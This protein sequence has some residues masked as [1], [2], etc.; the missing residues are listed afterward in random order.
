MQTHDPYR[1]QESLLQ[2]YAEEKE[3]RTTKGLDQYVVLAKSEE[4]KTLLPDPWIERGT[5]VNQ[6]VH[7]GG[8]CKFLIVGAGFSGI[9]FA[10]GLIKAGFSVDDLLF[11]DPAGGFGGAWYVDELLNPSASHG[12]N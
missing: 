5:S 10:V 8:H 4:F 9:L 2:K 3:K 12:S 6:V 1:T 7:D 11:V